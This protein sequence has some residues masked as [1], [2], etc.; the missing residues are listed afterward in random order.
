MDDGGVVL[1]A[2]II[3][4]GAYL[5]GKLNQSPSSASRD[6]CVMVCVITPLAIPA[7]CCTLVLPDMRRSSK[8]RAVSSTRNS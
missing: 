3:F 2:R 1:A 6:L 8:V 7:V 4:C 5:G